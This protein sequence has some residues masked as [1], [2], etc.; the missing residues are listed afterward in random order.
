[1][2]PGDRRNAPPPHPATVAVERTPHPATVQRREA[3][4]GEAAARPPHP[5]TVVQR[6]EAPFGG[7]TALPPHPATVVQR[8]DAPHPA[9]VAQRRDAPHPAT[10]AQTSSRP[11][12]PAIMSPRQAR[13]P[14]HRP[15][16]VQRASPSSAA[17]AQPPTA[18]DLMNWKQSGQDILGPINAAAKGPKPSPSPR[19]PSPADDEKTVRARLDQ[20]FTH[21]LLWG[22]DRVLLNL[23]HSLSADATSVNQQPL[24]ANLVLGTSGPHLNGILGA[25]TGDV[26]KGPLNVVMEKYQENDLWWF[27]YQYRAEDQPVHIKSIL[28]YRAARSIM[29]VMPLDS[30]EGNIVSY[31]DATLLDN[32]AAI[33]TR[34]SKDDKEIEAR[35]GVM[36][37]MI[38]GKLAVV[39][40]NLPA[41]R[42]KALAKTPAH[43]S[44]FHEYHFHDSVAPAGLVYALA[45]A[46]ALSLPAL[47]NAGLGVHTTATGGT[48]AQGN[49]FKTVAFPALAGFLKGVKGT[50]I[51][52]L[53]TRRRTMTKARDLALAETL[54]VTIDVPDYESALLPLLKTL[55]SEGKKGVMLHIVRLH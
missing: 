35:T 5:A 40:S 32:A 52:E 2:G 1:V 15:G 30:L 14:L 23:D 39:K 38:N 42:A 3:P 12:H 37:K 54:T 17:G 4:S 31:K 41:E 36:V 28:E 13:D 46:A 19:L 34:A 9:T 29:L 43:A 45:P 47:D 11:P 26:A 8:R 27:D 53:G 44:K 6:R 33:A 10:V 55:I 18:A 51:I 21:G 24:Y 16:A 20:V 48:Y 25:M 49:P 22:G 7:P 50:Q